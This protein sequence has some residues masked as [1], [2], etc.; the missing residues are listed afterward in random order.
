MWGSILDLPN[1]NLLLN[2]PQKALLGML[3]SKNCVGLDKDTGGSCGGMALR[4]DRDFK[5]MYDWHM[6]KAD[7]SLLGNPTY[8]KEKWQ[9]RKQV[10]LV[11]L[12]ILLPWKSE[13]EEVGEP[14]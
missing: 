5:A 13:R 9:N 8:I 10:L 11:S 14:V 1:W 7:C 2:Q 12:W 3:V 4:H 6:E